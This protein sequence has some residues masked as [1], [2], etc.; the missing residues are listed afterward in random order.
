M[1][2]IDGPLLG[3]PEAQI[4]ALGQRLITMVEKGL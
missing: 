3:M 2:I 1:L 4:E